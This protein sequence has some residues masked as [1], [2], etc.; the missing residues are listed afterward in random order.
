MARDEYHYPG[1]K[2][3]CSRKTP[4]LLVNLPANLVDFIGQLSVLV[5]FNNV[6]VCRPL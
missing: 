1:K 3:G 4:F 6:N 2:S 5:P